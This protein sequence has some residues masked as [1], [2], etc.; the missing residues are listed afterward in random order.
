[1][2]RLSAFAVA[3]AFAPVLTMPALAQ[4]APGLKTPVPVR[5]PASIYLVVAPVVE[6]SP[7]KPIPN[8]APSAPAPAVTAGTSPGTGGEHN[9]TMDIPPRSSQPMP[10]PDTS[11]DHR[12]HS[13]PAKPGM[14]IPGM[15][16]NE[17]ALPAGDALAPPP[18][19]GHY[20]DRY[21]PTSEMRRART[22]MMHEQG[23]QTLYQMMINLAEYQARAGRNGYRWSGEAW[24]GGD[25]NRLWIK[26]EGEA[27]FREE[28]ESA[29]MQVL[30]SRA[31]GPYFNF[32]T[33]VRHDFRPSPTRTYATVG[34]EGLA[35]YMFEVEGAL[36]I[37]NKGEVLGRIEGYYDQ[38][39]TQRLILQPRAQLNLSL[40]NVPE[41]RLGSGLTDAEL[42][43]RLRYEAGRQFAPY[44][45]V[46]YDAK[47]GRTANLARADGK[48]PTATS[49]VAGARFWF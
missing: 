19:A 16:R 37:S 46:S 47:T 44:I 33:G 26:S 28:V 7:K 8:P 18:P 25:I 22:A 11:G 12:G 38:R 6:E 34:F 10:G 20:A 29:E 27:V 21:F 42:G 13:M 35:P 5:K 31:I 23:G 39:L 9:S 36:F 1:M 43:L 49:F 15:T 2:N 32:Q 3:S 4:G 48:D 41:I 24:I 45:G 17:T 30:Y 40:Q 14:T